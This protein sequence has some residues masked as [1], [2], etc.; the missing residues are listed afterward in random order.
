[1]AF[2]PNCGVQ[3]SEGA[4]F[5]TSCGHSLGKEQPASQKTVPLPQP[6][7][8]QPLDEQKTVS[9]AQSQYQQPLFEQKTV[10]P[11]QTQYQQPLFEQKKVPP[12]Q[13]KYQQ[14]SSEPVAV[15][16][17]KK[18]K[19]PIILLAI[20]AALVGI[21][22]IVIFVVLPSTM[23]TMAGQDFYN[24]ATNDVPSVKYILGEKRTVTGVS[25]STR[26]DG[27]KEQAI[28]YKSGKGENPQNDM[29]TY[30]TALCDKYGFYAI[31]DND[32]SGV[33]G[34]G[35]QFAKES[36]MKGNLVIV[37]IDYDMGG[38]TI[39]LLHGEGT[40]TI[41]TKSESTGAWVGVWR[42]ESDV[43]VEL[44]T[45]N[46]DGT[47]EARVAY[48]P[49]EGDSFTLTGDYSIQENQLVMTNLYKNGEQMNDLTF[50]FEV[51]DN[52]VILNGT[53]YDPVPE[54]DVAA[55]F[56]DPLAPYPSK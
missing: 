24:I 56:A 38:Y 55:V 45:L 31:N 2:C 28:T 43:S 9:Q 53:T 3:V 35:F 11:S 1:M 49:G 21:A 17:K 36:A 44:L 12:S 32:F 29:V 19:L 27:V 52:A 30:A 33:T 34:K 20:F 50:N 7:Y 37:Q 4:K 26:S 5:C 25:T 6:Q 22:L 42:Y 41:P 47:A 23:N 40:L 51:S 16:K 13:S 8:Q 15:R 48:R 14:P 54:K 18:S 10:P 46:G 39:T